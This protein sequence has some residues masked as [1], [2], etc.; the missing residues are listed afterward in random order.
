[1][2]LAYFGVDLP[3]AEVAAGVADGTTGI[4]GNWPFNTAFAASAGRGV[5]ADAFVG[6]LG[7]LE[8]AEAEIR[9]G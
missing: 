7:S 9:R 8:E 1:M 4:Y 6:R 3:T 5:L 2:I